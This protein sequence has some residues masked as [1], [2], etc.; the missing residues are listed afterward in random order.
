MVRGDMRLRMRTRLRAPTRHPRA[1]HTTGPQQGEATAT[2]R[3]LSRRTARP[4]G[5]RIAARRIRA[6]TAR[7]PVLVTS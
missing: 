3:T 2:V 5:H 4:H 1:C 6:C 7:S